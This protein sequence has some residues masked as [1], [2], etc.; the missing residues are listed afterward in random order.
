MVCTHSRVIRPVGLTNVPVEEVKSDSCFI[1]ARNTKIRETNAHKRAV[2]HLIP[3]SL[4]P[5]ISTYPAE[6][7]I[8]EDFYP[9]LRKISE[10]CG[11]WNEDDI[12]IIH[13]LIINYVYFSAQDKGEL[14]LKKGMWD[15]KDNLELLDAVQRTALVLGCLTWDIVERLDELFVED[16]KVNIADLRLEDGNP[17]LH[18]KYK[19]RTS[20]WTCITY[21]ERKLNDIDFAPIESVY[22]TQAMGGNLNFYRR[23]DKRFALPSNVYEIQL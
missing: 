17:T 7:E 15:I 19:N 10:K 9:Q 13:H 8:A 4:E 14:V 18:Q 3:Q 12:A 1:F 5:P 23:N 2:S 22:E 11:V 6:Y 20:L 16:C 21:L